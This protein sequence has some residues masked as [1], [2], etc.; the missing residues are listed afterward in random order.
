MKEIECVIEHLVL[1]EQVPSRILLLVQDMMVYRFR[2][3]SPVQTDIY[4]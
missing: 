2:C 1:S 4:R 3:K